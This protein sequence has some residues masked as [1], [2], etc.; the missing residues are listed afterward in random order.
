MTFPCPSDAERRQLVT[1]ALTPLAA[2]GGYDELLAFADRVFHAALTPNEL[3]HDDVDNPPTHHTIVLG[4]MMEIAKGCLDR[5]EFDWNQVKQAAAISLLHDI[6]PV[7]RITQEAIDAAP[8]ADRPALLKERKDSVAVHM[9]EGAKMARAT[10]DRLDF[11]TAVFSA[12]DIDEVCRIIAIHDNPKRKEKMP[13]D[14]LMAVAFREADRL[15]MVTLQGVRSDL[16]RKQKRKDPAV[17]PDNPA[18]QL[19]QAKYN[20]SRF[21]KERK[22]YDDETDGPFQDKTT[23]FRTKEGFAIYRRYLDAWGLLESQLPAS[24][25]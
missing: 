8:E 23:L 22:L 5:G 12:D 13:A 17:D 18:E 11:P 6:C 25:I 1:D 20:I 4:H 15:W 21:I 2:C 24:S 9:R 10:L 3:L 7:A 16:A 19:A 14:D